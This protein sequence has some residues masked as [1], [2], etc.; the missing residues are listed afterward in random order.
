[1]KRHMT[2]KVKLVVHYGR[3]W[4]KK[5]YANLKTSRFW[6]KP[7]FWR[8]LALAVL[9]VLLFTAGGTTLWIQSLDISPLESP[10]AQPTVIYDKNGNAVSQLSSSRI[11]P[12]TLADIPPAMREAIIAVEDRRFYQHRGVDIRSLFRA[13][14]HDLKSGDFSEGGST[15]TQQLAKNIFLPSDKTLARKLKEAA[16]ALKIEL[17]LSKD[18]IL[19]AYLNHIY[20]GEGCWGIQKAAHLYF[21][22]DVQNLRL[23]EAALLAGLI[24]APSVY[25]PLQDKEKALERRDIVLSLMK[26]QNYISESQF[27]TAK[28]QPIRIQRDRDGELGGKYSPYVDYV[29]EEAISRYGFT[30]DQILGGGL[31]IYTEMDP[32]VQQAAEEVYQDDGFFPD[33]KSDQPVQSGIV[34]IDQYSGGIR[35]LVGYRGESTYRQ[36]NHAS[37]LKRQPG[38]SFKPLAV[39]GPALEMGYTPYSILYDGPLDLNGYQPVDWDYQSR[40]YVTMQEAIQNSWNIPAVWLLNEIGL[41]LG[42]AFAQRAGIPLTEED[43]YLS[44]ALGGL[45]EGVSPLQMAQAYSSFA[46]SGV[47]HKAFAV[48]KITSGD[49]TLLAQAEPETVRVTDPGTAY[50]LTLLLKNA[51]D[52]G[53]GKNAYSGRPTAG[54]TGSVELPHTGEFARITKGVKDVWFVGYTPELTAAVWMGYD[55]TDKDHY[56]TISGG[57]G[58]A[59]VFREVLSRALRNDPVIPFAIPAGYQFIFEKEKEKDEHKD[60]DEDEG[61]NSEHPD[62]EDDF[63]EDWGIYFEGLP[64]KGSGKKETIYPQD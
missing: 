44:L 59:V 20:F 64:T 48:T 5:G 39:Y 53:T 29:I 38:S 45:T 27:M 18:Q 14:L 19:T 22:K 23:G 8:S 58:P 25:S 15:I 61:K 21:G 42:F 33:G 51:V 1:M 31:Q 54:K 17:T 34:V 36:F 12:V 55:K 50:T 6:R 7:K 11:L 56:L 57:S 9:I 49:G 24:K 16:F 43:R 26:E 60:K 62:K 30:E 13:L 41:D 32:T 63:F 10:L 3:Q 4:L 40:G 37:Q 35:G 52:N 46:N 28:A 47:M 2:D